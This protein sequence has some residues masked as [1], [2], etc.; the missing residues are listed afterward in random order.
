MLVRHV[1][2]RV[3]DWGKEA[4]RW[5]QNVCQALGSTAGH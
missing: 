5:Q 2:V 4:V 1:P 3:K